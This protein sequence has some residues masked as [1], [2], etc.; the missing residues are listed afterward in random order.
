LMTNWGE[1]PERWEAVKIQDCGRL[2]HWL[3]ESLNP[4]G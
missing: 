4:I 1:L 3:G 2:A